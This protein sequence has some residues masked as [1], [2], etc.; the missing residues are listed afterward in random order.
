MTTSAITYRAAAVDDLPAVASLLTRAGLPVDG[1]QEQFGEPY[2][3]AIAEGEIIGAE[4]I[5]CYGDA[6]LLRSA[7]VSESWRGHGIGERL[8]RDRLD[9]AR[10]QNLREVW[11]LTTTA[12]AWFPR[13]GFVPAPRDQAPPALQAS[14][15]FREACP[16]SAT[17]MRL[18]F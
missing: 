16:A 5:E 13:F 7:V 12:D 17:A 2:A 10:R 15:E 6:G 3:V 8:T 9:W 1:L 18:T 4:G 11:L 14:R